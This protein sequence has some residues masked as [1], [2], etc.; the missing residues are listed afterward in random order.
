MVRDGRRRDTPTAPGRPPAGGRDPRRADAPG[1]PGAGRRPAHRGRLRG[2]HQRRDQGHR[3]QRRPDRPRAA[4]HLH[5]GRARGGL[6]AP[7]ACRREGLDRDRP[8]R[9]L[10]SLVRPLDLVV[11]L[12]RRELD[13]GQPRLG[14][15]ARGRPGGGARRQP[16]PRARE[17]RI[18][19]HRAGH[20]GGRLRA[21]R[22]AGAGRVRPRGRDLAPARADRLLERAG[23]VLRAGGAA[24]AAPG[25]RRA[26]R[27]L[28]DRGAGGAAGAGE[29]ARADLLARRHRGDGAGGHRSGGHRAR[30]AAGGLPVGNRR[31]RRGAR[32][33][34]RLPARRPDHRRARLLPAHRRWAAAAARAAD[35]LR[36]RA[37]AG[38]DG[39]AS[40][41]PTALEPERLG[42]GA[43]D[44]R[45][46]RRRPGAD[47]A[48]AGRHRA[49]WATG[50]TASP[51]RG[52]NG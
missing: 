34:C 28:E 36:H 45:G 5:A 20:G 52:R 11:D 30:P 31:G 14:L 6:G 13:R 35:R 8:A 4:R 39:V 33:P 1:R 24:G 32:P 15:R 16:R 50:W 22:Q 46:R 37:R 23:P 10:R 9:R 44:A 25:G 47:P 12:A 17:D 41:R 7:R 43:Q 3:R 38:P 48:R 2:L 26:S 42:A 49:G 29:H 27:Q 18:G 51:S 21:G 19:L 40:G